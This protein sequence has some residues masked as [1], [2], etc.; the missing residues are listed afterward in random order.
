MYLILLCW[1]CI[2]N[3]LKSELWFGYCLIKVVYWLLSFLDVNI[4]WGKK[5]WEESWRSSGCN[6]DFFS[7]TMA[8]F[9]AIAAANIQ[10]ATL[11]VLLI[12]LIYILLFLKFLRNVNDLFSMVVQIFSALTW[13][14]VP[15]YGYYHHTS[16]SCHS[17]FVAKGY[18]WLFTSP[19][20]LKLTVYK[21]QG[22]SLKIPK[23]PFK[24]DMMTIH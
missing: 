10:W 3:S 14:L 12:F 24:Y 9:I 5:L 20:T 13:Y 18:F 7:L 17:F 6:G 22:R 11:A 19:L 8:V 1:L 21:R 4:Q 16:C 2:S 15:N 23:K